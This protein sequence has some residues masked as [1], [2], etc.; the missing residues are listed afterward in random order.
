MDFKGHYPVVKF[1]QNMMLC[2]LVR[3]QTGQTKWP[4]DPGSK[5]L[6]MRLNS[7]ALRPTALVIVTTWLSTKKPNR[8]ETLKCRSAHEHSVQMKTSARDP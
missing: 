1:R 3:I 6:N 8:R 5:A 7:K 2:Q 4:S